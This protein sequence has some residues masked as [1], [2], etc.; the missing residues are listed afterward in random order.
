MWSSTNTAWASLKAV[1]LERTILLLALAAF[2][3]A[4]AFAQSAPLQA[5]S[6]AVAGHLASISTSGIGSATFYL[7]GPATS[8]K[9]DVRMGEPISLAPKELQ[10]AGMYL[11]ILCS[12]PCES[13][14]FYVAPSNAA[15]LT[16][17][18]HPS[19]APT[20]ESDRISGVAIP[21]DEFHNLVLAPVNVDVQLS[22]KGSTALSRELLTH[23][24]VAWFRTGSGKSAGPLQI[25]ASIGDISARRVVQQVASDPCSLRIKGERTAKGII[26]DT[27]PVRDCAGNPVPDGTIVTFTAKDGYDT[28]TVDAPIKQG[29][30]R[31]QLIASGPAVISAASGVVMGNEIRV[32]AH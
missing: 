9:R 18:V 8:L 14:E 28:D 27:E 26:V 7:I 22:A 10:A 25:T 6:G 4:I 30:A 21:F 23:D 2:L 13:T 31:A 32:G 11:A 29:V 15:A 19:R 12:G 24:G 17:L 5:P 20:G 1:I 16:F 3:S